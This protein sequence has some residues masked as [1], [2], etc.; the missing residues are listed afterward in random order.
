[1]QYWS[2]APQETADVRKGRV[3]GGCTAVDST[4][5]PGGSTNLNVL[6]AANVRAGVDWFET[7]KNSVTLSAPACSPRNR[8]FDFSCMPVSVAAVSYTSIATGAEPV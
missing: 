3:A 2:R 5:A 7:T 6:L 8:V 4:T 1:M